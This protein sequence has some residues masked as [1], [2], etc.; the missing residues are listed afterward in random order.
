VSGVAAR[1]LTCDPSLTPAQVDALLQSS[2]K[3]V[4]SLAGGLVDPDAALAA[5]GCAA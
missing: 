2:A 4:P 1:L 5:A 3:P